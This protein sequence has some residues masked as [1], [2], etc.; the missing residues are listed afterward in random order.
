MHQLAQDDTI[1]EEE[2]KIV[3][4]GS[5]CEDRV[6]PWDPLKLVEPGQTLLPQGV[7]GGH[8]GQLL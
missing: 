5:R 2:D 4:A 1:S 3:R 7:H 8:S 6:A